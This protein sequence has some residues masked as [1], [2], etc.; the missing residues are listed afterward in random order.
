MKTHEL[1]PN[2]ARVIESLR[3]AGYSFNTAVADIIDNSIAAGADNI[4]VACTMRLDN[5][6][7]TI[8]IADNGC[9]M[10]LE[11]ACNAMTY[12]SAERED[13]HSLG[14]FGLGLKTASTSQCRRLS[15]VTRTG[16]VTDTVKL[17]LDIDYAQKVNKWAYLELDPTP[18]DLRHLNHV[19]EN[20]SGTLVLWENCDRIL[21]RQYKNPGSAAQRKALDRKIADL[22]FHIGLVFQRFLDSEDERARNVTISINGR[23]VEAWDP[24]CTGFDATDL[25]RETRVKVTGVGAKQRYF[26]VAA[27]VVPNRDEVYSENASLIF[28]EGVSPDDLQGIYVYRENRLIKWG[29]WCNLYKTEFHDRLCRVELSFEADLD[30]CFNVDFKKSQIEINP[31]IAEWLKTE[32]LNNA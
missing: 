28:P 23:P 31:S 18:F 19:A 3:D 15:L 25:V 26:N 7:I 24:F 1:P 4:N 16:K 21:G 14:K 29:D 12:G 30:T 2:A 32:V 5:G 10:T 13:I 6:E 17:V 27:Y 22:R 9:G 11:E 8:A 20:H